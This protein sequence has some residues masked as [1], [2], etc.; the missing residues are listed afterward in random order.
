MS[1]SSMCIETE[2]KCE[3]VKKKSDILKI[4]ITSSANEF[5]VS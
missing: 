1:F 2:G 4:Q 5:V 3:N